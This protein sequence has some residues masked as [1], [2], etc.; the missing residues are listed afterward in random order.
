[1]DTEPFYQIKISAESLRMSLGIFWFLIACLTIGAVFIVLKM[2]IPSFSI[3]PFPMG[4]LIFSLGLIL[5]LGFLGKIFFSQ[6]YLMEPQYISLYKKGIK[7]DDS[8]GIVPYSEIL[9][10]RGKMEGMNLT[11]GTATSIPLGEALV[12]K[13]NHFDR[14]FDISFLKQL[15]P[16]YTDQGSYKVQIMENGLTEQE[17]TE[18]LKAYKKVSS[19]E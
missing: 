1:M 3:R 7:F 5:F 17:V 6:F 18:F 10:S 15:S 12:F 2:V 13:I 9:I 11:E 8:N 19:S 4:S 16:Q 14:Y